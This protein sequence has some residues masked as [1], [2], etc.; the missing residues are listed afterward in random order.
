MEEIPFV[1]LIVGA[2]FV[3]GV[4]AFAAGRR[5]ARPPSG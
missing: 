1:L 5:S 3:S 4:L 2:S